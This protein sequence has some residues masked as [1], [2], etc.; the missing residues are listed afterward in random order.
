MIKA[1]FT[2]QVYYD[3]D[4]VSTDEVRAFCN[5]KELFSNNEMVKRS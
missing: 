1:Q 5:E 2:T 4:S 3:F